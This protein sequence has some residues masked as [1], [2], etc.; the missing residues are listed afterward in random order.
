MSYV[1]GRYSDLKLVIVGCEGW[2]GK[3]LEE[4]AKELGVSLYVDFISRVPIEEVRSY[5]ECCHI[6]LVPHNST[7]H[8]EA[9]VPHKLFQ[10]MLFKKPLIV[11]SCKSLKRIVEDTNAGVA[12]KAGDPKDLSEKIFYLYDRPDIRKVFSENGYLEVTEGKFNW[13]KDGIVLVGVYTHLNPKLK[14]PLSPPFISP[15]RMPS[16]K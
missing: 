6:G 3:R 4:I 7:P 13:H 12:F 8:T 1:K 11:S 14:N 9:T 5:F 16:D 15:K 2:Y 10:Y